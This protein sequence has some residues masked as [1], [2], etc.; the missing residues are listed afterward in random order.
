MPPGIHAQRGI[1]RHRGTQPVTAV[2]C[3]GVKGSRVQISPARPFRSSM[4]SGSDLRSRQGV[5][6]PGAGVSAG[7][8]VISARTTAALSQLL[9]QPGGDPGPFLHRFCTDS[10]ARTA[11]TTSTTR[12]LHPTGP[13]RSGLTRRLRSN[14]SPCPPGFVVWRIVGTAGWVRAARTH[15]EQPAIALGASSCVAA[16]PGP[17][18]QTHG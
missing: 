15:V 6:A 10:H 9:S 8:R 5:S 17:R 14:M 1:N 16:E 3:L 4:K 2:A 7:Q 13:A 18:V 12:R 11:P